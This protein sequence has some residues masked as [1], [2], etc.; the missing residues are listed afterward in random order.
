M[1]NQLPEW[2]RDLVANVDTKAVQDLVAD[3]K[4]YSISPG[5]P[6]PKVT[7]QGAGR[8][9]D[10][11]DVKRGTTGQ[12]GWQ[13]AQSIDS[14]RPPGL[15]EMDQL[16]DQADALDKAERIS[17]LVEAARALKALREI[18]AEQAPKPEPTPSVSK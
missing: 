6:L 12:N 9:I 3:F 10:G 17:K 7:V 8:V 2:A 16:M 5:P 1:A 15:R 4:N 18:E 11:D 13:P 14:W